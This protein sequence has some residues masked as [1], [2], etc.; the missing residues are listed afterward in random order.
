MDAACV[1]Q[2]ALMS[3]RLFLAAWLFGF[4][5]SFVICFLKSSTSFRVAFITSLRVAFICSTSLPSF[6]FSSDRNFFTTSR[7]FPCHESTLSLSIGSAETK[8]W[9]HFFRGLTSM[10]DAWRMITGC[11]RTGSGNLD[12]HIV[13]RQAFLYAETA[14]SQEMVRVKY[15]LP[16]FSWNSVPSVSEHNQIRSAFDDLCF[17]DEFHPVV[18]VSQDGDQQTQHDNSTYK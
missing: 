5:T 6:F 10:S 16:D 3:F 15:G 1:E 12:L 13:L 7:I 2:D 18:C 8:M 9:K 11:S 14:L 17:L 4:S